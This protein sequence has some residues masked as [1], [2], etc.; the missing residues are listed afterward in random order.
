[1]SS[2]G[3]DGAV[4]FTNNDKITEIEVNYQTRQLE[5]PYTAIGVLLG[6]INRLREENSKLREVLKLSL[7]GAKH[8]S[9]MYSGNLMD[10]PDPT[11]HCCDWNEVV[12]EIENLGVTV[13]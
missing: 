12:E 11:W 5:Y 4:T 1:M 13:D 8:E 7:I 6:E 2:I 9:C 10:S 3:G